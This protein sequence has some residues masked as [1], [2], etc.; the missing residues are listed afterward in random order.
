MIEKRFGVDFQS[1]GGALTLPATEV[2]ERSYLN[3]CHHY[4]EFSYLL[5]ADGWLIAGEVI[6]D[7][8]LWVNEFVAAHPQYGRVWGNFEKV[9]YA[10]TEEG[11]RNF[12]DKHTPEA[13]DY[14]DI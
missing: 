1:E 12:Y 5:H 6:E 10:D 14:W 13:W 11:F 3:A 9:V 7:Y 8:C 4:G 2:M